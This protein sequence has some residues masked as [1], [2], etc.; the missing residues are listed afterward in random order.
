MRAIAIPLLLAGALLAGC[1]GHAA[2]Q[3][4]PGPSFDDL[5][6][7]ATATTGVIRG[8]AVDEA[9]R[10]IAGV[11]VALSG[12]ATAEATTGPQ[13]TFGFDGL[14]AGTYFLQFSKLGL[15]GTQQSADVVPGVVDPPIVKVQMQTDTANLPYYQEYTFSGFTECGTDVFSL[16]GFINAEGS[17][18][19]AGNA[20]HDN[21][22]VRYQLDKA[23]TWVQSEM[24]W[25][26]TQAAGGSMYLA[27]SWIDGSC[28]AAVGYC[29]HSVEGSSPLL[30]TAT[31]DDI[32]KIGLG[33]D[34]KELYIRVFTGA[35]VPGTAGGVTLEQSFTI[36]THVFYG[37]QPP[38]GWRFSD[39]GGVP[40]PQ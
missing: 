29:D 34:Q 35:T 26:S 32:A 17:D 18:L 20:T 23:P 37:Y 30:L 21:N 3:K 4:G 28:D 27:Y 25:Q 24:V 1:S 38:E 13:G 2:D 22:Q 16:C 33:A 15:K 14:A 36:Y 10:P 9:I 11:K 40:Q 8:V 39:G 19:G 31:P 5:G 7:Q 12:P 6:L